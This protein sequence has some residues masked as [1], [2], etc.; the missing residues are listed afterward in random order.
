MKHAEKM[1]SQT[2]V[3]VETSSEE[4]E[5]ITFVETSFKE[6]CNSICSRLELTT[7]LSREAKP[8]ASFVLK[9]LTLRIPFSLQYKYLLYPRNVES[10]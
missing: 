8:L 1:N 6:E 2:I 9:N 10:F 4:A 5:T 3:F 7:Q